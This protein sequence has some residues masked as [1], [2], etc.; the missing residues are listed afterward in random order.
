MK[1]GGEVYEFGAFRLEIDERRLLRDGQPVPLRAKLFDTLRTLVR[2][3]GSLVSKDALMRE[4][5]PDAAVEEGNLAHNVTAL[6]KAIGD[7]HVET[8][9]GKGY[10]FIA[11]VR[12][13]AKVAAAAA[14]SWEE[15]LETARAALAAK[16]REP[17]GEE[18]GGSVV[19]RNR[20]L[21]ELLEGWEGA[22]AGRACVYCITGEPGIGKTTLFEQFLAELRAGGGDCALAVGRCSERLGESEA[23]L[24]VLEALEDLLAG[25]RGREFGELMKLAAPTW[26]VQVAPL[27]ASA[28]PEFAAIVADAKAASRERMKRDLAA[29]LEEIARTTPV[30]VFLDD[31][32]WADSPT[33][34][35]VA[36]LGRRLAAA[37]LLIVTAYRGSDIL[38]GGHPF[39]ALQQELKRQN[40][41]REVRMGLLG[42]P[43][44]EDYLRLE[45][46]VE[47]LPEGLAQFIYQRTEGNPL[48]MTEL[49]RQLRERGGLESDLPESVRATIERRIG[50]LD[51]AEL[52][53]LAAAA[54]E[55]QEFDSRIVADVLA[56]DAAT[57]EERLARLDRVHGLVRRLHE[58]ELPDSSISVVYGFAHALY[59]HSI[60]E[61]LTPSRKAQLSRSAG[62]A[63]L[64]RHGADSPALASRLAMLFETARDFERAAD[65]F[66]LAAAH[67]ARLYAN[68]EAL[69]MARRAIVNAEALE[70]RARH[71]RVAAGAAQGAQYEMGLSRFEDAAADFAI[72]EQAAEAAGDIEAQVNAI[73]AGALARFYLRRMEATR[74]AAG[75]ALAIAQAAGSETAIAA[76]ESVLAME[77]L[78]LGA[79][80]EAE[81]H[82][83]RSVPVLIRRGPPPHTLE[84][85]AFSGLLQA[86]QLDFESSHRTVDWTLARSR[87]LGL[88]YHIV[89]CLYVR[90]MALFNQ[91]RLSE[92]IRDLEEGM[93]LA[94]KNRER[95]W[96]SRFPNTLGWVYRELQDFDTALR[97]DAEG[98]RTARENGYAKPEANSHLNLAQDYMTVGETPRALEHL[99]RAAQLFEEDLWFRWRYNIRTKAGLARYWLLQGDPRQAR[100]YALESI[101]LAEPC[102]AR[103]HLA[104]GHKILGDVSMAEDRPE[105]ARIDYA[106]ALRL[107]ERHRCPLIE[108]RILQAAAEAATACHNA[109]HADRY[110]GQCRQVIRALADS[111]AE[112]KLRRQLLGSEAIRQA[113]G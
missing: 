111:L 67:A 85:V 46:S 101:Q 31:L 90:G 2:N 34:E 30:L 78:C 103:K 17:V 88:P 98:A 92:G 47:N 37:R 32:H 62:E 57:A 18:R 25:P 6:R 89:L 8:V 58:R 94:D 28:E 104:W 113:I 53:M 79:S 35:L 60:E 23:Y 107:L 38:L 39:I 50:R 70:G 33:T 63:L 41:C 82:Y 69:R 106:T 73:C 72:A 86:W 42:P 12:T 48:F 29:F 100:R 19:G 68:E 22:L 10:R 3:H 102:K 55:G 20:E 4:V 15:R 84:S 14:G 66:L 43:E 52:A 49:V 54:V 93:R 9:P 40:L 61:T 36:Y 112:E 81:R 71:I 74:E 96:L 75:R 56:L 27:W 16:P 77:R 1:G 13:V 24:P 83:S 64:S 76:A 45:L 11:E 99:D 26:Y 5:W 51:E 91:G 44:V 7:G 110:R 97:L 65:F 105:D 108:W 21:R 59:R 80:A 95:F 87:E 109:D